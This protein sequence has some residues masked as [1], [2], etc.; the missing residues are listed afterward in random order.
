MDTEK[1]LAVKKYLAEHPYLAKRFV[2]IFNAMCGNC[3]K[4]CLQKSNRP[5]HEYCEKCQEMMRG[6]LI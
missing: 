3:R 5:M 2:M 6:V 1:E 4:L